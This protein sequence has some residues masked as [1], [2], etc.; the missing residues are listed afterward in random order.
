VGSRVRQLLR[1]GDLLLTLGAGDIT[2]VGPEV[3]AALGGQ[4]NGEG[5]A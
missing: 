4:A 2:R 5:A 1:S 3:M